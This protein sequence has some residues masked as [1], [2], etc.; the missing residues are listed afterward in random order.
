MGT[1]TTSISKLEKKQE[2]YQGPNWADSIIRVV[3]SVMIGVTTSLLLF[4]L[5][6]PKVAGLTIGMVIS[7]VA[8]TAIKYAGRD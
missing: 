7:G 2:W 5:G 1:N 3:I 8:L 6:L 4:G